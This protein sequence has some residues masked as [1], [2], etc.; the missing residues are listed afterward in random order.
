MRHRLLHV[1]CVLTILV[2]SGGCAAPRILGRTSLVD[3]AGAPLPPPPPPGVTLNFI[4]LGGKIEESVVSVQTDVQGK[5][6][7]PELP[8][9]KYTVEAVL[10]GFVIGRTTVLLGKH[11]TKEAPFVLKKIRESK[12]KSVKESQEENIPTPGEVKIKPPL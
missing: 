5:Y 4:N 2:G 9:G 1:G 7:S 11:G 6:R 3:E 12:G 8:P 10:P